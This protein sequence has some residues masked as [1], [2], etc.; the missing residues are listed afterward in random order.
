MFLGIIQNSTAAYLFHC[1]LFN[2]L[3]G[4]SRSSS[5]QCTTRLTDPTLLGACPV[6]ALCVCAL[7]DS[8][9]RHW[10]VDFLG[11]KQA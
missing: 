6:C 5:A 9:G 8:T 3:Y 2:D 1:D 11:A 4:S 10:V 7:F